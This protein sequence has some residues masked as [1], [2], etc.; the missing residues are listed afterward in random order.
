MSVGAGELSTWYVLFR[1]FLSVQQERS[2]TSLLLQI[3]NTDT[4]EYHM[5]ACFHELTNIT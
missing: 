1:C 4:D 5:C 3:Q 2:L